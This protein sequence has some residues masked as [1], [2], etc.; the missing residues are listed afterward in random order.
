MHKLAKDF[1][2]GDK[3]TSK[4]FTG[5]ATV[6]CR[7]LC[8]IDIELSEKQTEGYFIDAMHFTIYDHANAISPISL[9]DLIIF[10]TIANDE[11]VAVEHKPLTPKSISDFMRDNPFTSVVDLAVHEKVVAQNILLQEQVNTL[12]NII[13]RLTSKET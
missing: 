8:S 2:V 7:R 3:V 12:I 4:L 5:Y 13:D 9:D 6:I 1:K 10:G 11:A